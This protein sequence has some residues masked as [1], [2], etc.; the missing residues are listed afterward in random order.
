M[1]N[2]HLSFIS[3]FVGFLSSIAAVAILWP[4]YSSGPMIALIAFVLGSGGWEV[5]RRIIYRRG[6]SS[7]K[8]GGDAK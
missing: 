8:N 3:L 1:F 7:P 5:G 4:V 2:K 6:A